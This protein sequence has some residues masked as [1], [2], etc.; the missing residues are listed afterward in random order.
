MFKIKLSQF[1]PF[2]ILPIT[3]LSVDYLN[4]FP[5]GNTTIWWIV[6]G[7][8][9]IA[10]W[11]SRDVF[12]NS[13]DNKSIQVVQWYLLWNIISIFHGL[14]I[15]KTYWDW[16]GLI[17]NS[18]GLLVPIMAYTATNTQKLQALLSFYIKYTLPL[19]ILFAL[20]ISTDGYGIYL[21]P[22]SLL[23]L[24]IPLLS[25]GPVLLLLFSAFLVIISDLG[26]RSNVI[27]F[28]I[29]ILLLVIYFLRSFIPNKII[30]LT[31][32]LLMFA[33]LIFFIL[34]ASGTFNLF[35]IDKYIKGDY[36]AARRTAAGN[37]EK[38]KLTD[39]TRTFLYLE[40]L[41]SVQKHNSWLIGR[42][43]ARGNE[44][45]TFGSTD[46]SGRN[47]RLANEVGLL[48]ILMWTGVIGVILYFFIFFR[49]S[50]LA[51]S[52]SSNIFS[53]MLGIFVAFRWVYAWVEDIN[54][55]NINYITL[56]LMIG[57]CF[58]KEFRAMDNEEVKIWA[59]GIF[60][61]RYREKDSLQPLSEEI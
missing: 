8:I 22:V 29:P 52:K 50:Y 20:L 37:I 23:L 42:S 2:T 43:P 49:A 36:V 55:F 19:F 16:K 44:S 61:K 30:E 5:I 35:K 28:G 53:K 7:I 56:W 14:F 38:D 26:A 4:I 9:L 17:E 39:D 24:F 59:R 27:R 3:I 57:F 41:Q 12:F 6:Q 11:K 60:N 45:A 34:A 25:I 13:E 58:S 40:V 47:E 48:N 10:F 46:M 32:L 15:A 31:R 18:M 1:I 33:P 54:S 51:V 21:V